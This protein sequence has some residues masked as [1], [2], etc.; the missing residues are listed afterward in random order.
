[1]SQPFWQQELSAEHAYEAEQERLADMQEDTIMGKMSVIQR[2]TEA[3]KKLLAEGNLA[4]LINYGRMR[5]REK[6]KI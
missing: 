3:L 1:M 4:D 6:G 5:A 2:K